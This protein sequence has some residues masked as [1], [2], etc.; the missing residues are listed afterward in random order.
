M[1]NNG[2]N[3]DKR[4]KRRVNP[5]KFIGARKGTVY[6]LV[7]LAIICIIWYFAAKAI[8]RSIILPDFIITMK[9]F[10]SNWIDAKVMSNLAITLVRV[11]KGFLYAV[12][13]GLPL[14]L[15]MGFSKTAKEA[16]SPVMNS[17]RQVPIMA[18]VPLSIIWFGLGDGPTVFLIAIAAVFPI[19]INTIAGVS[20]IDPNYKH[21]ARMIGANTAKVIRDVIIPGALP[22][23]LTGCR[24]ALGMGWMLVICAEFIATSEGFGFLLVEAQR[25]IQTAQLFALMIM[26]ALVGFFIDRL[27]Q[28]LEKNL[29]SW[30]YKDAAIKN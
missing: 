14:G 30:R 28:L 12:M 13:I 19:I 26:S 10:F 11:F 6:L 21:A 2:N 8:N 1:E 25:R 24:I 23:I 18:W 4:P 29:T 3:L 20:G 27:L 22:S 17:I 16:I 7:G 9:A 5:A 15:I